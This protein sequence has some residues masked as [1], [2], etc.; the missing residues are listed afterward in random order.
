V[1]G[2]AGQLATKSMR[3]ALVKPLDGRDTL[4][5]AV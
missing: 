4:P 3:V 1:L 5:V 2:I